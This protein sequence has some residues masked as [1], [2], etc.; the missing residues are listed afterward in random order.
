M[1]I[2]FDR[3]RVPR[4]ALLNAFSDVLPDGT[5]T[6]KIASVSQRFGVMVGGLTTGMQRGHKA[7]GLMG[8]IECH[9]A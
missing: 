8:H 9:M 3:V 5:Y 6:S 1:Q 2:W 4:D 7:W